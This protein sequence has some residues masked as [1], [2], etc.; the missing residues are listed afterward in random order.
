MMRK[1]KLNDFI[2]FSCELPVPYTI[3]V[4]LTTASS[5]V[6]ANK[7]IIADEQLFEIREIEVK[8]I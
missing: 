2:V 8:T 3:T 6:E 1:V 7:A 5:V 4:K